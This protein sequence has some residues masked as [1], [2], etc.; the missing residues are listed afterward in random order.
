MNR[1][2]FSEAHIRALQLGSKRDPGLIERTI[3]AFGLLDA[4]CEVGLPF[5]FKGG[6]SLMLLLK[7]PRRL[8][9]DI[10]II[11][12]PGTD[13]GRYL[14]KA[15][16]VFPFIT[17]EE[18]VR[19]GKNS[20]EKRHFKFT[21]FSPVR[22]SEFYILLD[23]LFEDHQYL[24]TVK[25]P[26]RNDLLLPSDETREVEMPDVNCILGDKMTAFAPHTTGIPLGCEK[27]LEVVKQFYDVTTLVEEFDSL[28]LVQGTFNRLVPIEAGYRGIKANVDDV[29]SDI[30]STAHS[31]GSRGKFGGSDYPFLLKGMKALGGHIFSER[32][33]AETAIQLAPQV[34]YFAEC[35]KR[36]TPF[37]RPEVKGLL[38]KINK[39][40]L[41]CFKA[42]SVVNPYAY[43][44]VTLLDAL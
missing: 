9:T 37:V 38:P 29:L 31:I 15:A 13:I 23:V 44:Y 22:N 33:S 39:P 34:M 20:I 21:Y 17:R 12:A 28:E 7:H 5:V 6:T 27:D 40:E 11:V 14:E 25:R 2:N 18:Q 8:S 26:I 4:L 1:D 19:F 24:R 30:I 32:F 36:G 42:L 43:A 41:R 10:D 16:K 3:F 35:M